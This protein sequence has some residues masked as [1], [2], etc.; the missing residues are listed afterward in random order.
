LASSGKIVDATPG[1]RADAA[2]GLTAG[3]CA[4]PLFKH[5]AIQLLK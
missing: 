5:P 1:F 2:P 4:G 3:F